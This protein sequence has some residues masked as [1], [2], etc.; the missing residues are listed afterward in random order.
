MANDVAVVR[1]ADAR[2]SHPGPVKI[3]TL[4]IGVL[5]TL[6][7]GVLTQAARAGEPAKAGAHGYDPAGYYVGLFEEKSNITPPRIILGPQGVPLVKYGAQGYHN[8]P[9]TA[10]QY[11]LWAYGRFLHDHDA[12]HR[13]IVLR[14]ADWLVATQ[15]HDRW[16][17]DFNGD[18]SGVAL[19]KPWTSAMAQG[20]A[21]S[22][23]ERAYRLTGDER[24][25]TAALHGLVPLRITVDDGGLKRCFFGNCSLPFL[26]EAPT[27][28][29]SYI[30]NGFMFTLV[31][32]YD[33][34]SIAPKSEALPMY[35]AARRTL[36]VALPR[37][38][39]DGLA[40][41]DLTHLTVRGDHEP[42]IATPSYQAVHIYLLRALDS[43]KHGSRLE[44]YANRWEKGVAR[45]VAVHHRGRIWQAAA[46]MM[47]AL[48][49]LALVVT[50]LRR[51]TR[52]RSAA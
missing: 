51:L 18:V 38:D 40:S 17:Y 29:P 50:R 9:V 26:E 32:L 4:L 19:H 44:R 34:A 45:G 1:S 37:Y 7:V 42:T 31:G 15:R 3:M 27:T 20:Q 11:G 12:R 14:V 41:Y 21:M 48:I 8:N 22:L 43:I 33:L 35:T 10:A 16:F 2:C 52:L 39:V 47:A 5:A 46:L 28:P 24:Y 49:A 30:L 36:D 25:R 6:V 23:L 13:A